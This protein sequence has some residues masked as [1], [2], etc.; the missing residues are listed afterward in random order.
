MVSPVWWFFTC[1][2]CREGSGWVAEDLDVVHAHIPLQ[3]H[4]GDGRP[5]ACG[6]DFNQ[7]R[8]YLRI[9][10]QIYRLACFQPVCRVRRERFAA[11]MCASGWVLLA[12]VLPQ[13]AQTI[14]K[15]FGRFCAINHGFGFLPSRP[16][17]LLWAGVIR[18]ALMHIE[19]SSCGERPWGQQPA[20]QPSETGPFIGGRQMSDTSGT[21]KVPAGSW[22]AP[23]LHPTPHARCETLP[24]PAREGAQ[25]PDPPNPGRVAAARGPGATSWPFG[26]GDTATRSGGVRIKFCNALGGLVTTFPPPARTEKRTRSHPPQAGKWKGGNLSFRAQ[27]VSLLQRGRVVVFW[28]CSWSES[29]P[30]GWGMEEVSMGNVGAG[31]PKRCLLWSG[32]YLRNSCR[33]G[34]QGEN[35]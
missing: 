16:R 32:V 15:A 10:P 4:S 9:G 3:D 27:R 28:G 24:P 6:P 17:E 34:L 33:V 25:Q 20:P 7:L 31:A 22:G 26:R 11:I 21:P 19:T 1:T 29:P 5:G 12:S 35:E 13:P 14:C 2:M 30:L 23:G 18:T 8:E